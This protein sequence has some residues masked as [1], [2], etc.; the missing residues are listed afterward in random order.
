MEIDSP[1]TKKQLL[2]SFMRKQEN[3]RSSNLFQQ[4][5][6]PVHQQKNGD[7][8]YWYHQQQL[9]ISDLQF[10][11]LN[12]AK[13]KDIEFNNNQPPFNQIDAFAK[14]DMKEKTAL[15]ELEKEISPKILVV[16]SKEIELKQGSALTNKEQFY[17]AYQTSQNTEL[18][19]NIKQ[20]TNHLEKQT[21]F[22]NTVF[23][24]HHL[25]IQDN[26]A[27]CSLSTSN[28]TRLE[29]KELSFLIKDW[30]KSKGIKLQQ[31][32]INGVKHG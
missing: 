27:E 8:Y 20:K 4:T 25:F 14:V 26:E 5:L 15:H 32:I 13:T 2:E 1:N 16:D 3:T 18:Q 11:P 12:Q 29:S 10:K 30:L 22:Q 19:T 31:L 9:E 17:L 21:Q 23:K 7:E 24:E 6:N 28:L